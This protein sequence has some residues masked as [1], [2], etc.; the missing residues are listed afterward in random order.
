MKKGKKAEERK[1]TMQEETG[2]LLPLRLG[3]VSL[4]EGKL[5]GWAKN[6]GLSP[7]LSLNLGFE[8][9][10]KIEV[11]LGPKINGPWAQ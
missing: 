3:P 1:Q 6:L 2:L 10:P 8:M 5:L 7:P 11:S 4:V 9:S